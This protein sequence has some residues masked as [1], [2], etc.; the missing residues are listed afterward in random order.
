MPTSRSA[1]P[2]TVTSW[3]RA[4]WS[5]PAL[6][7]ICCAH[8]KSAKRTWASRQFFRST[9]KRAWRLIRSGWI[10][11]QCR[12]M[13]PVTIAD[14]LEARERIRGTLSPTALRRYAPLEEE[15]GYGIRLFVKHENHQPTQAFKAR[16]GLAALTSLS[17]EERKKGVV[18]ASRGNH[19]QGLAW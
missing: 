15:V 8:P 14:V 6:A 16:N 12:A 17:E 9:A 19:G 10:P 13:W 18:G 7:P 1:S 3:R 2:T 5:N 4:P 11:L